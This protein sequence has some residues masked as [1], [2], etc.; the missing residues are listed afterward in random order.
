MGFVIYCF[1]AS[2]Y[3]LLIVLTAYICNLKKIDII[4]VYI[5]SMMMKHT[6]LMWLYPLI[7]FWQCSIAC[8]ANTF[9]F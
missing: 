2:D 6:V 4:L 8:S 9:L 7:L 5:F 1:W 3:I